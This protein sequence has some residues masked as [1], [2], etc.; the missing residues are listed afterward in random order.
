MKKY[1]ITLFE[2]NNLPFLNTYT[3]YTIVDSPFQIIH[4][5]ITLCLNSG[6]ILKHIITLNALNLN[7]CNF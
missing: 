7:I 2:S 3:F 4:Y 6:K 1:C 5:S